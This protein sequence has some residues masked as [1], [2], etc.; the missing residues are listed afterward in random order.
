M[1]LK[2]KSIPLLKS[3]RSANIIKQLFIA[4][5]S[6]IFFKWF[7]F[8]FFIYKL[9]EIKLNVKKTCQ[10]TIKKTATKSIKTH[11]QTDKNF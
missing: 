4:I 5:L 11:R 7:N 3:K 10:N 6:K 9:I 8:S 2:S 1:I